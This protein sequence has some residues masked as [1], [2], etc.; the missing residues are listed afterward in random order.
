[1]LVSD[2]L[3]RDG[4]KDRKFVKEL[5]LVVEKKVGERRFHREVISTSLGAEG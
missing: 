3:L 1:M 5:F 4:I 2:D